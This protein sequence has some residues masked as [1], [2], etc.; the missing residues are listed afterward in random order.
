MRGRIVLGAAL[1]GAQ[2]AA[3][4]HAQASGPAGARYFCWAP[5]HSE[6][7]YTVDATVM[8]HALGDTEITQRYGLIEH[9]WSSGDRTRWELNS[10]AHVI[11]LVRAT[12]ASLPAGA[13]AEVTIRY[14]V[15][16]GPAELWR[17]P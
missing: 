8:G 3:F 4:A 7:R 1:L 15:N 6:A 9:Y 17:Y 2:V 12:E 5:F 10:I 13:R 11:D 14:R 16:G